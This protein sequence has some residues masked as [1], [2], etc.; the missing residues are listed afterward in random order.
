MAEIRCSFTSSIE[1]KNW[2]RK[3]GSFD[4]LRQIIV[5]DIR[6]NGLIEPITGNARL[7]QDIVI[8]DANKHESISSNELNSRK[9]AVL[10]QILLELQVRGW[11]HRHDLRILGAEA[12]SRIAMI[13][14]G[15]YPFYLGTEYL[16]GETARDKYF[17]VQHMDL[18][19]IDFSDNSFDVFVSGDVFKHIP[20]LD[21]A[22]REIHRI[23]K[24]GAIIVSSFL[25]D[26]HR[27]ATK[28]LVSMSEGGEIIHHMK[29][30][31]H[32]NPVAPEDG[33]LV[34][35]LPGWDLLPKLES[36]GFEE[37]HYSKETGRGL[38][39]EAAA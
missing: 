12:L 39:T 3:L 34:F 37:A 14:R 18:Q 29:P 8:R 22:L 31:Y 9:R 2:N 23:L 13:L 5:D 1:W 36:W 7:P 27:E 24:P 15:N 17:P 4:V 32:G 11:L 30:E 21:K 26:P 20:D 6:Q 38:E 10:V 16:P 19:D 33:W 28:V 25:F 35:Q